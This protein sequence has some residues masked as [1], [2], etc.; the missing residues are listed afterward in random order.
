LPDNKDATI[1]ECTEVTKA[2]DAL[3]AV[4]RVTFSV[5]R[6]EIFAMVGP[7]GAG[8][9][10]LFDAISGL[11]PSTGGTIRF[12]GREIQRMRPHDICSLGLARTFQ[13]TVAFD[14][15][16]VLSNS[17]VGSIFG[18]RSR[19]RV[20]LKFPGEAVDAALA[21][22]E[23]CGLH[24]KQAVSSAA[25]STLQRKRLMLA[26]ALATG[27]TLLL[28]DEPF[29]GLNKAERAELIELIRNI[30]GSGVSLL[31]I[32]HVVKAVQE[33]ADRML[34][35]DHGQKVIEGPPAKVL[36]DERVI[37]AYFGEGRADPGDRRTESHR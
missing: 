23:A 33:L 2:Y 3:L 12:E 15:Q 28:L 36:R 19:R 14:S 32:E 16:N 4:N 5:R 30:N 6:G 29:G 13:T 27:P 9:T 35:L 21:A 8:K 7:N 37:R 20:G 1:L 18:S 34:V 31:L 10:T 24:D 25:L 22:L 11:A 26:T 17:L